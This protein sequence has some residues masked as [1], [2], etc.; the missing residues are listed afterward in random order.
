MK[1][2]KNKLYDNTYVELYLELDPSLD[3]EK[4]VQ[5]GYLDDLTCDSDMFSLGTPAYTVSGSNELVIHFNWDGKRA[6]DIYSLKP[7]ITLSGLMFPVKDTW[8]G[9]SLTIQNHG[10]IEGKTFLSQRRGNDG[11]NQDWLQ[12]ET[13]MQEYEQSGYLYNGGS[14]FLTWV[15]DT[16][17]A[18]R[19]TVGNITGGDKDDTFVFAFPATVTPELP[20]EPTEN[21][22]EPTEEPEASTAARYLKINMEWEE[23]LYVT[24]PESIL[25]DIYHEDEYYATV[26]V[27]EKYGWMGGTTVPERWKED[28]WQVVIKN[29]PQGYESVVEEIRQLVFNMTHQFSEENFHPSRPY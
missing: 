29:L 5:E 26:E 10:Y 21:D 22:E 17:R 3:L 14:S 11:N 13:W 8:T 20:E 15:S 12:I 9:D 16:R 25:V 19:L 23:S 18:Y 2:F 24:L 28:D 7:I 4:A 27:F 1:T 6:R